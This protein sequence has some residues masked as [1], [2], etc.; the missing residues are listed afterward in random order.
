MKTK[1]KGTK[2]YSMLISIWL[3]IAEHMGVHY[4]T[5]SRAINRIEGK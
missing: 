1:K 3:K 5:V 2:Q 4:A